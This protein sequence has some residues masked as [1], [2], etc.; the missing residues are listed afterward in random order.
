MQTILLIARQTWKTILRNK[1]SLWLTVLLGITLCVATWIGWQ[2][3]QTQQQQRLQYSKA[4][5]EKWVSKPDKHPHRMAHYGYL[6]FRDKHPLSFFDFG[7]ESFSGVSV[8]LEAHKQNTVNFS[9]AGFSNGTLRFGEMSVAMVLQL[10]VP[11]LIFFL[12]Y[13]AIAGERESGTLKILLCQSVSWRQL[14]IG[15]TLGLIAVSFTLFLPVIVLTIVLWAVLSQGQVAADAALRLLFLLA[16]YAVYFAI[17]A[18]ITVLVSAVSRSAKGALTIL[19]GSWIFFLVI[20][21]RLTQAA[22]A[23]IYPAPSKIA[24]A[25][26]VEEDLHKQGDSHNPDDPHYAGMKA[27]VLQKY[28][29]KDVKDLPFNY[30]GYVMAEGEKISAGIYADHLRRLTKIYQQQNSFTVAASYINPYLAI[31]NLSM[32]L[33]AADFATYASFQEQ[34]EQYRYQLAQRM[35]RLQMEYISNDKPEVI[36][37]DHWAEM[38]DF[39]YRFKA[40]RAV[41]RDQVATI[42]ALVC[43]LGLMTAG[44]LTA[45]KWAR[46]L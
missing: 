14:M 27:A 33:T 13:N 16:A 8:F 23:N 6:V 15:K 46:T 9:E 40:V 2:H 12:G 32:A 38:P 28:H 41:L 22:G 7:I 43:W 18:G 4:V 10:L 20:L 21:P 37:H 39:K 26:A 44:L 30:G 25:A 31:R 45:S 1:A 35:N 29:V 19:L 3:Y 24:F 34:V 11:L 5:R 36:S 42:M 17:C